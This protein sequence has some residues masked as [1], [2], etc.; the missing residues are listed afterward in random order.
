M[1]KTNRINCHIKL[2]VAVILILALSVGCG[3]PPQKITKLIPTECTPMN[4]TVQPN[5]RQLYLKWNTDCPDSILLSGYYIYISDKPLY[6][7]YGQGKPPRSPKPFND[8]VYPGDT[9]PED[10]FETITI[11]NLDNGVEYYVSVRTVLADQSVSMS[12]NEV[13]IICRPEGEFILAF[14]YSDLNDGFSFA[15]GTAIRA[16]GEENDL[17]F[18]SKDGVDYIASP[19]RLNGFLRKSDFYSL[20][21]TKDIYQYPEFTLDIPPVDRM[22]VRE[23]ESYL[24]KTAEGNFAKMRIEGI[25]GEGKSRAMKIRYIYQTIPGLMRF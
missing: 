3:A 10:K 6:E 25:A 4:L 13:G 21:K 20:G 5:D 23:G 24:V 15:L 12:S 7:K 11:D 1:S 22:P 17:Y 9:D 19:H 14:R 2:S 16:D 8:A 18:Y